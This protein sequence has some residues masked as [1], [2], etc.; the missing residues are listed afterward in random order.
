MNSGG[1]WVP[2][3]W[4][5]ERKGDAKVEGGLVGGNKD[6]RRGCLVSR[7]DPV[8]GLCDGVGWDDWFNYQ[9]VDYLLLLSVFFFL[10]V[11]FAVNF[12]PKNY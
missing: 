12:Q 8:A 11:F 7:S 2:G 9:G 6:S 3:W 1:L 10:V 5:H 4:D